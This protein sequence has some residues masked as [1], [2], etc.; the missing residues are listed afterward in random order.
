MSKKEKR[1]RATNDE[2]DNRVAF[3]IK[4]FSVNGFDAR[5]TDIISYIKSASDKGLIDWG[6]V[7]D[8]TIYNYCKKARH[9]IKN[10]INQVERDFLIWQCAKRYDEIFKRA[11][12]DREYSSAN[13]ANEN[14]VKLFG[15]Q[16]PTESIH[17]VRSEKL[18]YDFD[19][20]DIEDLSHILK[21]QNLLKD[22]EN[23]DIEDAE[24]E[25]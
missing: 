9:T 13:K 19:S 8:E 12:S 10:S 23:L 24:I 16:A 1:L 2:V 18:R 22:K 20:M 7:S 6:H 11:L 4:Y 21:T 25:E 15:L 17:T 3:I 14:M 5:V